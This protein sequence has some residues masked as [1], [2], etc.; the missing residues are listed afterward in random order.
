MT[1]Q[2]GFIVAMQSE[3]DAILEKMEDVHSFS[4][5]GVV[6]YTGMLKGHVVVAAL[7]GV[8][9]VAAAMATTLMCQL[10]EPEAIINIGVAGGLKPEQEVGD[11]VVSNAIIQA[12]FDTSPIDGPEGIGKRFAADPVLMERGLQAAQ[13]LKL[14]VWTG[15][16]A[17]QDLFMAREKDFERLMDLFPEA[18]CSEMEGG[19]VAQVCAS[20]G[21]PVL[22][23]R[24]LSDVVHHQDN[25]MEFDQFARLAAARAADFIEAWFA[26]EHPA[27]S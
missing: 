21:V 8:G 14:P 9:K 24:S 19:A 27:Q 1:Q 4:K 10:F 18:A 17:T 23:L 20:F 25:P 16:V 3:L 6:F 26:A 22:A 11:L 5:A 13:Q 2:T 7:S 15:E 12:D